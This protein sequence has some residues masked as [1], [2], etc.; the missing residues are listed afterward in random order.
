MGR[1]SKTFT[2]GKSSES[3]EGREGCKGEEPVKRKRKNEKLGCSYR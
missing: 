1:T 2:A 3:C